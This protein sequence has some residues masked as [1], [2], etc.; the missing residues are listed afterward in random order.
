MEFEQVKDNISKC[1]TL[2]EEAKIRAGRKDEVTL[3][4]ATKTQS[5]ELISYIDDN[6]LLTDVGENRVQEF[7]DKYQFG[8]GLKWH[9]I[10]QLQTNKVKYIID[11]AVLIHSL[12]RE[13]LADE[14]DRQAK[15]R[16]IT[17]NCLIEVN[18]GSEIS[19]GGVDPKKLCELLAYAESKENIRLRGLMTVMPNLEDK[20]KLKD[21]CKSF[22]D[23]YEDFKDK[24]TARHDID[25]L[26]CGMT[27]DYEMAIEYGGST[28]VRLGRSL[29]GER[30]Y[31]LGDK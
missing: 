21:L 15:K 22:K 9:V 8:K 1:L 25:T 30:N 2:I 23:L 7:V 29:F 13:S 18:M 20:S 27:N 4:G 6:R 11:K 31:N 26:S 28:M 12:D 24:T 3:I 5:K 14:I 10:G 16:N 17:A 19:K